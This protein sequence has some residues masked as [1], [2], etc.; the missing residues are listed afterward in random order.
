M[1]KKQKGGKVDVMCK[2][3]DASKLNR[4]MERLDFAAVDRATVTGE[5]VPEQTAENEERPAMDKDD[6]DKL[7][8]LLLDEDG[9]A[10]PD[11][12]EQQ[13]AIAAQEAQTQNPTHAERKKEIPSAQRSA[14]PSKSER[15]TPSPDADKRPSVRN[16]LNE[17]IAA[18]A[19]ADE[20]KR[21]EPEKAKP[22]P[23]QQTNTHNQ[24]Q[25]RK[26]PNKN[27]ER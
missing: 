18:H 19:K 21:A 1:D 20:Q 13:K 24:P 12:P 3:E 9:K 23:T 14:T 2:A 11:S 6:T 5:P 17:R 10:K 27:K 7:L 22:T 25:G 15:A 4:I 8:D 16:K 26:K